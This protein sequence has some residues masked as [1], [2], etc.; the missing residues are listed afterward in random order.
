MTPLA[1]DTEPMKQLVPTKDAA[2]TS[3]NINL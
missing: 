2:S 1:I 3:K